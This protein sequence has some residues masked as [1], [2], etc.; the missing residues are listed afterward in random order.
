[1]SATFRTAYTDRRYRAAMEA[2]SAVAVAEA[3]LGDDY[4]PEPDCGDMNLSSANAR[5]LCAELGLKHY[6]D[7]CGDWSAMVVLT[8]A[9]R[10]LRTRADLYE[11]TPTTESPADG[12]LRVI[13]FG[14][15]PEYMRVRAEF[16]RDMAIDAIVEDGVKARVWMS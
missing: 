1:M 8:A 10:Y 13:N 2:R 5:A 4:V 3:I 15:P 7:L 14:R 12:K 6:D 16:L 11:G 9:V